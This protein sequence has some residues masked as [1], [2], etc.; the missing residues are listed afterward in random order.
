VA[1]LHTRTSTV[2]RV[3]EHDN[4]EVN[5]VGLPGGRLQVCS[6]PLHLAGVVASGL[7]PA[8]QHR[9]VQAPNLE[10]EVGER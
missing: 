5:E 10:A 3:V 2:R 9:D 1:L 8:I 6:Q 7:V 4:Y